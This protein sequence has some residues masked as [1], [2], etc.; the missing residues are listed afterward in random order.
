MPYSRGLADFED[1][2]GA[3]AFSIP[4]LLFLAT[5]DGSLFQA[6]AT[7][8]GLR[9]FDKGA[10]PQEKR[11]GFRYSK[12]LG[13]EGTQGWGIDYVL[14]FLAFFMSFDASRDTFAE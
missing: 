5:V 7:P 6:A 8:C 1:S 4:T 13:P 10:V 2:A 11:Q 12:S 14:D 9:H 3:S